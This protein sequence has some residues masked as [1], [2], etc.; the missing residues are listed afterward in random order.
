M[1]SI[2]LVTGGAVSGKSRWA[3]SYF[4]TCDNVLYMNTSSELPSET[5]NSMD[6]SDISGQEPLKRAAL[7]AAAGM[8]NILL[9]GPP[10]SGKTMAAER[11]PGILP[12]LTD[13]EKYE[14]TQIYSVCGKLDRSH[15]L[16]EERPFR[17]IH[18]HTTVSTLIGGG[19]IPLPGEISLAHRGVLFLDEAAEF[20]RPLLESLRQPIEEGQ[21][22]LSRVYGVCSFPAL[23]MLVA[24][25]NP[26]PCG[27]FPDRTRC[28]CTQTQIERYQKKISGALLDR[29]DLRIEAVDVSY[30]HLV[31][32]KKGSDTAR[33][34][35]RSDEAVDRQKERYRNESFY[36]NSQIPAGL[37]SGYCRTDEKARRLLESAFDVM[38]LS[39]RSYHRVLKVS[40]TIADLEGSD[41]IREAHISE[42]LSY[43]ISEYAG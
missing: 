16:I 43:R 1:A 36:F 13:E 25:M 31:S 30:E 29:I 37:I 5:R 14:L 10:G 34:R 8:H 24:A 23:F 27:Y 22:H 28:R 32:E 33:L 20:D 4:R 42:A 17:K 9:T 15:P 41:I 21:I 26:C 19:R 11:I 6:F 40:R 35:A 12:D 2:T 18:P 39:A 7:V 3:I 38:R